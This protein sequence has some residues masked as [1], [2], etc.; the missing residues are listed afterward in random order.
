MRCHLTRA[1][2]GKMLRVQSGDPRD[3]DFTPRGGRTM[4]KATALAMGFLIMAAFTVGAQEKPKE[5]PKAKSGHETMT[6][7]AGGSADATKISRAMS[8]APASVSKN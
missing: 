6:K 7:P 8:A 4:R 3:S 1:S 5:E 2:V